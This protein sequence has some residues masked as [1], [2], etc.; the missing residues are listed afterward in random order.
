ML[1]T[2][3]TI[4]ELYSSALEFTAPA[5]Q[6]ILDK[7][8]AFSN[9]GGRAGVT[10]KADASVVTEVDLAA[11]TLLRQLISA[12]YPTHGVI[13]E[14]FPPLNKQA[15]FQWIL[16]PIDGTNNFAHGVPTF[17]IIIGVHFRGEPLVGV[18]DHPALDLRYSGARGMG[19]FCNDTRLAIVDA[20]SLTPQEIVCLGVRSNFVGSGDEQRFDDFMKFHA[21]C[22]IYY[23]CFGLTRA[24]HG[25][26]GAQV[27]FNL[28]LWDVSACQVLVEEAGGMYRSLGTRQVGDKTMYHIAMGK[29]GIVREILPYFE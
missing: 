19:A 21:N 20:E 23:D 27:T 14:E 28:N 22:R 10:L 18:I 11:E 8:G 15:D 16:D 25:Q 29:P 17:G 3:T 7:F 12:R 2:A 6:L 26:V 4:A 13:G 1:P 24:I 5:R 9:G